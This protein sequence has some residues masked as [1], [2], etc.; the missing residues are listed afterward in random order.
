MFQSIRSDIK[1]A[2]E[3]D[4]AA[5][6]RLEVLLCY[7]GLHALLF[8]RVTHWLWGHRLRLMARFL[9]EFARLIT[10]IDQGT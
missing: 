10:G 8:Y 9:S 5:K 7:P 2:L 6:N 3:R 4:P 1:A